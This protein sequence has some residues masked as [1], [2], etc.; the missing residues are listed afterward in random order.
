MPSAHNPPRISPLTRVGAAF[1]ALTGCLGAGMIW[2]TRAET[3]LEAG[4]GV[5]VAVLIGAAIG[6]FGTECLVVLT[7]GLGEVSE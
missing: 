7:D 3:G 6:W 5:V 1:G 2:A 4:G